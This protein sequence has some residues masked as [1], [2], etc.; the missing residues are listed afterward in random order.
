MAKHK[1]KSAGGQTSGGGQEILNITGEFDIITGSHHAEEALAYDVKAGRYDLEYANRSTTDIG[2]D[3]LR[4]FKK[5]IQNI[6]MIKSSP[7]PS[8][9][10]ILN[11]PLDNLPPMQEIQVPEDILGYTWNIVQVGG[12]FNKTIK[13][14]RTDKKMWLAIV[15]VPREGTFKITMSLML[16]GG[17]II[18]NTKDFKIRDFL[19][20]SLGDSLSAGQGNPDT[21]GSPSTSDALT[22][23]TTTLTMIAADIKVRTAIYAVAP[24][25]GLAGEILSEVVDFFG[26]L[27]GGS[28][29]TTPARWQEPR[30]YRSY[31]SGPSLAA[32]SIQSFSSSAAI[33]VA[34]LSFARSGAEIKR[35][36]IG[37][38]EGDIDRFLGLGKIGEI[39]EARQTIG[40]RTI[41]ALLISIGGNDVGFAGSLTN[42][43]KKDL[44]A[45]KPWGNDGRSRREIFTV[46]RQILTDILPKDFDELKKEI[47]EKL[48][49][50]KVYMLEYPTGLFE[51]MKDG[52]I[53]DGG[54]CGVFEGPDMDLDVKD[55][56]EVKALGVDLNALIKKKCDDFGW[57]FITGIADEFAG[58]GYCASD[59][60]WVGAEESC[61]N[62]ADF[63]GMMHPNEKGHA[64]YKRKIEEALLKNMINRP[65][66]KK[67]SPAV[68]PGGAKIT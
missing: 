18:T 68:T 58:H 32:K 6:S 59:T 50:R 52:Q 49:P 15:T 23:K 28:S 37:P 66:F 20:V 40:G 41:D 48:K 67:F 31:K 30:A 42:L 47:D 65:K 56:K 64:V 55:G 21:K 4:G 45:W 19:V 43:V 8:T 17:R 12:V 24:G 54:A 34:F 5:N 10:D 44:L 61:R 35:G 16:K 60:F 38:R 13:K 29:E 22:C 2:L 7:V 51:K 63:E 27:F 62:Q 14:D 36:L 1:M 57:I 39:E 53:I 11:P 25:L 26:G 33:R 46:V 9:G 3:A